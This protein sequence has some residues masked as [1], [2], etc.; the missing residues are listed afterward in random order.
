M[1]ER[2][3]WLKLPMMT[4]G[5]I[6]NYQLLMISGLLSGLEWTGEQS[7]KNTDIACGL[8]WT[9]ISIDISPQSAYPVQYKN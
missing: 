7:T 6:T 9:Y 4:S 1:A 2:I 3:F 8:D 5:N